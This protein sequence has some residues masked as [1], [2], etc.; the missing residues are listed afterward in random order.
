MGRLGVGKGFNILDLYCTS[1]NV[2]GI[3]HMF[4]HHHLHLIYATRN[5]HFRTLCLFLLFIH[6]DFSSIGIFVS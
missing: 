6:A 5:V 3:L 4:H 1:A 2:F